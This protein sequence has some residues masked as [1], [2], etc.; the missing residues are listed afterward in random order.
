MD[1]IDE[2]LLHLD[3]AL[4][5][6]NQA[7]DSLAEVNGMETIMEELNL[8]AVVIEEEIAELEYIQ[9]QADEIVADND[10]DDDQ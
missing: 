6:I 7:I 5:H 10:Y 2:N 1:P 8:Q 3:R 9:S 4:E